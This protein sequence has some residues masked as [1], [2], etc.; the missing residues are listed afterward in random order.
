MKLS[1]SDIALLQARHAYN[2][3]KIVAMSDPTGY[4]KGSQDITVKM[5]RMAWGLFE[6]SIL[7]ALKEREDLRLRNPDLVQHETTCV[8]CQGVGN[9]PCIGEEYDK[10]IADWNE[11][12]DPSDEYYVKPGSPLSRFCSPCQGTGLTLKSSTPVASD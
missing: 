7:N 12:L 8:D 9:F 10:Q 6:Q 11:G 2:D 1:P 5:N 4:T 3:A